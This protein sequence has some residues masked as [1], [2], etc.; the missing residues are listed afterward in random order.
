MQSH[1]RL[2]A[3]ER[4]NLGVDELA[5]YGLTPTKQD[6]SAFQVPLSISRVPPRGVVGLTPAEGEPY[7]SPVGSH[8][9][10]QPTPYLAQVA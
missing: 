6:L 3:N 4:R 8:P 10:R 1:H 5:W 9:H 2:V 7:S